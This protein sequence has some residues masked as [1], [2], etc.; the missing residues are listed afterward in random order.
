MHRAPRFPGMKLFIGDVRLSVDGWRLAYTITPHFGSFAGNS[1]GFVVSFDAPPD[2]PMVLGSPVHAIR[3]VTVERTAA[4]AQISTGI[5]STCR[6]ASERCPD[7]VPPPRIKAARSKL[8]TAKTPGCTCP[9]VVRE[10][11]MMRYG[12]AGLSF[13]PERPITSAAAPPT[14]IAPST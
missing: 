6:T 10:V 3:W 2:H 9:S 8:P 1:R 7:L 11:R 5:A 4:N 12:L 13:P 14:A